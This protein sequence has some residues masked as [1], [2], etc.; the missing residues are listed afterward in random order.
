MF[1][2]GTDL[3]AHWYSTSVC[4]RNQGGGGII[5][6]NDN[7]FYPRCS[8]VIIRVLKVLSDI[9]LSSGVR[10]PIGA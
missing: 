2:G 7:N 6:S 1:T 10:L 5:T 8:N 9:I 3:A 4:H